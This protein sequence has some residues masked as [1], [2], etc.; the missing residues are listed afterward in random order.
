MCL[1]QIE[2]FRKKRKTHDIV[3]FRNTQVLKYTYKGFPALPI[4][5]SCCILEDLWGQVS[6]I[7]RKNSWL[8]W[9][10]HGLL[11]LLDGGREPHQVVMSHLLLWAKAESL[12]KVIFVA[13]KGRICVFLS[14]DSILMVRLL[15]FRQDI[16]PKLKVDFSSGCR[17][18]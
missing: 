2:A 15:S 6:V 12:M 11:G 18:K 10:W 8:P 4:L 3:A 13:R 7:F 16:E 9:V 5:D 14:L 1:A 17:G